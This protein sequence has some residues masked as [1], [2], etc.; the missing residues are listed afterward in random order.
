MVDCE[1]TTLQQAIQIALNS[2]FDRGLL[3]SDCRTLV[4]AVINICLYENGLWSLLS[5]CKVLLSS[6]G[7]Y[8]LTF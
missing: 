2:G 6:S 8:N 7:S 3:E 4:N 1:A 5:S